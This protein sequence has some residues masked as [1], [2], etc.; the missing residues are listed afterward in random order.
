MLR[1]LLVDYNNIMVGDLVT[2]CVTHPLRDSRYLS[3]SSL[4]AN[5]IRYIMFWSDP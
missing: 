4:L 2:S 3:T 1:R 5:T